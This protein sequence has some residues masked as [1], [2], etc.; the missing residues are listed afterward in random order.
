MEGQPALEKSDRELYPLKTYMQEIQ[1][2]VVLFSGTQFQKLK[3]LASS[4]AETNRKRR[5][6]THTPVILLPHG[7]ST[8]PPPLAPAHGIVFYSCKR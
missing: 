6:Q 3:L 7:S 2:E 4:R 1:Q 5:E 8:R